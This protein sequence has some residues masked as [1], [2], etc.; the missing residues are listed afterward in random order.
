MKELKMKIKDFLKNH[1]D[2]I[3][4]FLKIF[5]I[6]FALN[7]FLLCFVNLITN[8]TETDVFYGGDT[9]RVL[10]DMT[11]QEGL[12]Y[13]TSVHPLFV[14]LTQ[15]FIR[16]LGR[17]TGVIVAAVIFEAAIGALSATL[18]YRFMQKLGV[19]KKTSLT[20][21][22]ILTL[23][24][25]QIAFNSI[26]ETY[27]FSQFGLMVMWVIAAGL[28]DKKLELKDYALLAVAGIFSLA[29]TL[30][31]IVQF[32]ILLSIIIFLNKNVKC[33]FI[34]F[35]S[36]LLVVL[37]I[38]VMLA[39]VQKAFWPSANNFFTSSINGFVLDKN[40]EEFTYIE[41][42]WSAK[43]VIFQMNTS[44]VYQFGLLGGL[45]LEKSNLINMLGLICFGLFSLI[46]LYYFFTKRKIFKEKIYFALLSAYGFNFVLHIF[47]NPYESFLYVLHY[48]FLIIAILFYIF[49]H[50]D[51][52]TRLLNYVRDFFVKYKIQT[53]T[54]YIFLQVIGII[55]Y[56]Q[57][58]H[59]KFG[60]K[61]TMPK[62]ILILIVLS[63]V[64]FAAVVIR[65]VKLKVVAGVV[66][67]IVSLVGWVSF[68]G[69]LNN[70]EIKNVEALDR[71]GVDYKPFLRNDFTKQMT[72]E[73][74]EYLYELDVPLRA[75]T[76]FIQ[77]YEISHKKNSDFFSF[78]M[79][80]RKTLIYK[81]GKLIDLQTKQT[82]RSFDFT[83]EMIIPNMYTVLLL[84][85]AGKITRIYEDETGV[86]I[87]KGRMARIWEDW[88]NY[89]QW[90]D[91]RLNN[92]ETKLV[93]NITTETIST[94]KNKINLPNFEESK[95]GRILKVLHQEILVNINQGKPRTTLM[96][97][98]NESGLYREGMMAAM[99]LEETKNTWLFENWMKQIGSIYDCRNKLEKNETKCTESADNPGQLLYLLGVITNSRQDLTNK[100]KAEVRQK[101]V[102]GEFVGEVDGE[103]M[104]YY[105]TALLIN[106]ARKNKIDLGYDFNLGKPDKYLGLTWWLNDYKEAKHGNIVDPMHPAKEWASVHQEPGHY[107]LTT[108]LD[109]AYPLTFDGELT[110]A[111][112]EE[113][114]LIN[115][116]YS[117]EKGPR[118]S[119]IWHASEMFLM[120]NNRE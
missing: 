101:A 40:S 52:K 94:S 25:T 19:S 13:R 99:V 9:P 112:A 28:I 1:G 60:F 4:E 39:D 110:E 114:K 11:M 15:P 88:N 103:K 65:K 53:M 20:A 59:A 7:L 90:E 84:D 27:A 72:N 87:E 106:G 117:H 18:F 21:T 32:L 56:L 95:V 76:Y 98:T 12:H 31:N 6:V 48:N 29:F 69:Y 71:A 22:V 81:K 67:V 120:L 91:D 83:H 33:K 10:Q 97:K 73:L 66:V 14:I 89:N 23:S 34:K 102:D 35:S 107:G 109:E 54:A 70:R 78:G 61:A 86:H 111:E 113:Q 74:A 30:T 68:S 55:K 93:E 51:E 82:V 24:F 36:I 38:T 44:F 47:Y 5:T 17:F 42:T 37:S 105:P 49:T 119:S 115:E 16:L 26:F 75:Q 79:G 43:R 64:I 63:L 80:D 3:K 50:L 8:G 62:Y 108:I 104:G 85:Q 45:I 96:A 116:H 58:V 92:R 77:K 100:I 57:E 46:N 41:R 2:K 118:L